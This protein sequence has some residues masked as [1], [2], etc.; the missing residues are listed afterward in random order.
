MSLNPWLVILMQAFPVAGNAFTVPVKLNPS[1]KQM[2]ERHEA[3]LA[4][5]AGKRTL[6]NTAV[7]AMVNDA[8]S[9]LLINSPI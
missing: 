9:R 8:N 2:F 3:A 6:V 7:T 1:K 5:V 4:L